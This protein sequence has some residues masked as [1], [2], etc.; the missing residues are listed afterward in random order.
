LDRKTWLLVGLAIAVRLFIVFPGPFES[1]VGL[2]TNNADLRNYYWPAQAAL[3]GANPY[4]LWSSGQ[5][6]E[7]RADMAPLELLVYVATVRTWNDPRAIQILFVVFDAINILLLGALLR[8]SILKFPFQIFYALG[9]LTLYNLAL[10]PEDKTIV[11]TLTF[12]IIY[13]LI[14]PPESTWR[15]GRI[16]V[17]ALSLVIPLA[18]LLASFKWLSIFY[19]FPLLLFVSRDVREFVRQAL[20][21]GTILAFAHLPWLPDWIYVYVFRA[22]RVGTPLHIAPAVLLNGVGLYDKTILVLI[23]AIALLVIYVLFWSKRLDIFETIALSMM[24]GILA[25]PDMDPVHLSLVVVCLLLIVNWITLSRLTVVWV[26]STVVTCVYAI[27]THGGFARYGLPDLKVLTGTYGSPQMIVWSYLLFL[28]VFV[29]YLYDKLRGRA[30]GRQV[31]VS[32][33][34]R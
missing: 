32:G 34:S 6:G 16:R 9:P 30:V 15:V 10:V 8:E 22:A 13:L 4:V 33:L 12:L 26:L 3:T 11:L 14:L 28:A 19:L 27:S 31:L 20:M 5:S 17:K 18:A 24:C 1:K 23:L 21:F 29:Y 2:F 25:T 7:F